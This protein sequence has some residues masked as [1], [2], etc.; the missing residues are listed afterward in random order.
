MDFSDFVALRGRSLVQSAYLLTGDLTEAEDV[1][2]VALMKVL[3]RWHEVE[4]PV[5]YTRQAIVRLFLDSK[6]K[7]QRS[8][9]TVAAAFDEA[10][11]PTE[12]PASDHVNMSDALWRGVSGL[13]RQERAVVVLRYYEDLD[14]VEIATVLGISQSSVRATASR[15]RLGLIVPV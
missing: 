2:Q 3:A 11:S 10:L 5:S 7:E 15:A 12:V 1:V 6:R 8:V 13:P 9:A 14:D 4:H